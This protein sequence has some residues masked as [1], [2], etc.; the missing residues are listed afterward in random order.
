MVALVGLLVIA[1][2]VVFLT[3]GLH[4]RFRTLRVGF[5][6]LAYVLWIPAALAF[7]TLLSFEAGSVQDGG[8]TFSACYGTESSESAPPSH[9]SWIPP[10]QVCDYR[11]GDVGPTY[12]R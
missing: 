5:L 6:V 3:L 7:M 12:W 2:S 4:A 1:A 8:S 9:W 11:S 10:G